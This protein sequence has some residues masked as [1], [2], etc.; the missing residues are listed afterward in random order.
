M[1][2][3]RDKF[4]SSV[5]ELMDSF[6]PT[7][8]N[9]EYYKKLFSKMSATDFDNYVKALRDGKTQLSVQ[10]PNSISKITL[11]DVIKIAEKYK[12]P[13]FSKVKYH[14][15]HTERLYTT[16][17]PMLILDMPIRRLSQYLHHKISL[18]E[19]DSRINPISGQVISPDKGATLSMVE[20]Q[21]LVSK[22]L[23]TSILELIKMRAGDLS[24]YRSI[25]HTIE[26][27]GEV[28]LKDVPLTGQPRSAISVKKFLR[29]M[30]ID[31]NL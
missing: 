13:I 30:M 12:T 7:G 9:S 5:Y 20:T 25:K 28:S 15:I 2:S 23:D 18:P 27:S 21:V 10:L 1:A 11:D 8:K 14:D 29:G 31:T 3:K 22:G 19:G 17:Y 26:E 16:K 24:A 4:E 6:D